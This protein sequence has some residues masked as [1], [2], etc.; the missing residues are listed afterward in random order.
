MPLKC[1]LV[2]V[3]KLRRVQIQI[4]MKTQKENKLYLLGITLIATL[5]GLLF[6]YDTAVIS[7]AVDPIKV[8][9]QLDAEHY[10]KLANFYHGSTV[11]SALIGCI[12]GGIISGFFASKLGRKKS[13]MIAS[14]FLFVSAVGSG[15]PEMFF[16]SSQTSISTLLVSFNVYRIIGGIGVGMASAICPM[17]IAE[18]APADIRGKLVSWNQF[19]IIFGMLVVYFVNFFI[20]NDK[21][22]EWINSIGWRYMFVSEAYVASV[23]AFMLLLV[24]ETPRYLTLINKEEKALEVLSKINGLVKAKE[25]LLEIKDSA[26]EKVE[27]VLSYG[28]KVLIICFSTSSRHQCCALL[29]PNYIQRF[30]FWK[31]CCDVANGDYGFCKYNFHSCGHL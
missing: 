12:I 4:I 16:F 30:R 15:Y 18:I 21:P 19:A 14:A 7:G 17:Y 31:Q 22:T 26:H 20:V 29:C 3:K 25:I 5:G 13:L 9:F 2:I 11:S 23:F 8:F 1:E 28:W 6:G 24:P 10:G 27:K